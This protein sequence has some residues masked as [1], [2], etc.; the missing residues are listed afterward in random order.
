MNLSNFLRNRPDQLIAHVSKRLLPSD[1]LG[2]K[3]LDIDQAIA[4]FSS[5]CLSPVCYIDVAVMLYNTVIC[6]IMSWYNY[7][8]LIQMY[9]CLYNVIMG[10]NVIETPN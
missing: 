9:G 8:A 10:N 4:S 6:S 3:R 7:P 5:D 2:S 1:W